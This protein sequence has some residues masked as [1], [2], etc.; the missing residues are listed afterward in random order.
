MKQQGIEHAD[1]DWVG[2]DRADMEWAGIDRQIRRGQLWI[3]QV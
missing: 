3:K 1:F 2:M